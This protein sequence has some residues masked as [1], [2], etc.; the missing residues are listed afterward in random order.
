MATTKKS[1]DDAAGELIAVKAAVHKVV[2]EFSFKGIKVGSYV[3]DEEITEVAV[4]A[5]KA[6]DE[7]YSADSI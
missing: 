4:A 5:I 6:R 1:D 2:G 7:Y 3:T